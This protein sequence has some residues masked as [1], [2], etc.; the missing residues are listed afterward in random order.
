[1]PEQ[2][3]IFNEPEAEAVV[4]CSEPTIEQV[5][6]K[7]GKKKKGHKATLIKDFPKN[8]IEYRL[9]SEESDCNQCGHPLHEISTQVRTELTVT[10]SGVGHI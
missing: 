4:F 5:L 9:T 2:I 6:P 10:Y 1:M 7:N 8:I 3:S